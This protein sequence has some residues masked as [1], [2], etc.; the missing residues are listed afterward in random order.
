MIR[1]LTYLS[2]AEREYDAAALDRILAVS[3]TNNAARGITGV[4]AY[5]GG[6]FL[7][8]LEG[9]PSAVAA[10]VS[11][12]ARDPRHFGIQVLEDHEVP[13]R[14]FGDWSMGF[15]ALEPAGLRRDTDGFLN[16]AALASL[17]DRVDNALIATFLR[18]FA[19]PATQ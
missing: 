16:A 18:R 17:A 4:L 3:R 6:V 1:Q 8:V 2:T 14:S 12:I 10:C 7:Q 13:A 9:V 11:T 15:S 5:G 19:T